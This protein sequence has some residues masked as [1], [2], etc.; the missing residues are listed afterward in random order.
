MFSLLIEVPYDISGLD[1]VMVT[2]NENTINLPLADLS[3]HM[4]RTV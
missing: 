3:S 1:V 2:A 4:L